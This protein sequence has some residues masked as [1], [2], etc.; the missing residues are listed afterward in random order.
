MSMWGRRGHEL[1]SGSDERDRAAER[2]SG[3]L[4]AGRGEAS[5]RLPSSV[6]PS[7]GSADAKGAS[8]LCK[9]VKFRGEIH[10]DEDL[11]VDGI[12][13]G[14]INIPNKTLEIGPNSEVRADIHARSLVLHGRLQGKVNI[15]ERIEI[16]KQGRLEGDLVTHRIVV[17]DGAVFCGTSEVH[18]PEVEKPTASEGPAKEAR[19][20]PGV[21]VAAAAKP[22]GPPKAKQPAVKPSSG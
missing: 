6:T 16:K 15:R 10:S 12:V 21:K 4:A 20:L 5:G 17:E 13:D 7:S 8:R 19:L 3:D 9:S 18:P 14:V 22:S 2:R 1:S 11:F